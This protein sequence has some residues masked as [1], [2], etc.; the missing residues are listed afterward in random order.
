MSSINQQFQDNCLIRDSTRRAKTPRAHKIRLIDDNSELSQRYNVYDFLPTSASQTN[1][2]K[3]AVLKRGLDKETRELVVLKIIAKEWFKKSSD[4]SR[5]RNVYTG[6]MNIPANRNVVKVHEVIESP[7]HYF[8][9][10]EG[11]QGGELF[12]FLSEAEVVP[13]DDCKKIIGQIV[14]AVGHLHKYGF[15]HRDLK[16]ENLLFRYANSVS[17]IV[18]VDLDSCWCITPPGNSF[19]KPS[20]D[21]AL[22]GYLPCD[23][24]IVGTHG[25]LAPEVYIT[26]LYSTAADFWSIGVIFYILMTGLPPLPI[27]S[28]SDC[29]ACVEAFSR[30]KKKGLNFTRDPWGEFPLA[31]SLCQRML[32]FDPQKRCHTAEEALASEWLCPTDKHQQLWK[33]TQNHNRRQWIETSRHISPKPQP[34]IAKTDQDEN[35][36]KQINAPM[37]AI[38]QRF[39][40]LQLRNLQN[41]SSVEGRMGAGSN[42]KHWRWSNQL[43]N[44]RNRGEMRHEKYENTQDDTSRDKVRNDTSREK[45]RNDTSREKVRNDTSREK[46]RNDTS[47]EKV[48][49]DTSRE[50]VRNDTSREKVRNDRDLYEGRSDT[51]YTYKKSNECADML[52]DMNAANGRSLQGTYHA[53]STYPAQGSS[54]HRMRDE[55]LTELLSVRGDRFHHMS[56]SPGA[57][58]TASS[59]SPLDV[60]SPISQNRSPLYT[61]D[62]IY[63]LK[64]TKDSYSNKAILSHDQ[65]RTK[66]LSSAGSSFDPTPSARHLGDQHWHLPPRGQTRRNCFESHKLVPPPSGSSRLFSR[67]DDMCHRA[68][69]PAGTPVELSRAGSPFLY[70]ESYRYASPTS[71]ILSPLLT[72]EFRQHANNFKYS[73][74]LPPLRQNASR[75]SFVFHNKGSQH[76]SSPY[77]GSYDSPSPPGGARTARHYFG[78]FS[79]KQGDSPVTPFPSHAFDVV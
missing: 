46:V 30:A 7:T 73:G 53:Q 37:N 40:K 24:R 65:S 4:E 12:D 50:K 71:P 66:L 62:N 42:E 17:E 29:N 47:R 10:M 19:Y 18:L 49:N 15:I 68:S 58:T 39:S 78:D 31:R 72:T 44:D 54:T 5:W 35:D 34:V 67:N 64:N 74:S 1:G 57:S 45:V 25:Y 26:R 23:R 70:K 77:G 38:Q 48:R 14:S 13:E 28:M 52:R 60:Y 56:A 27:Q 32:M 43:S 75:T 6:I 69:T 51:R 3:R 76:E 9:I 16:P 21:A 79:F 20:C 55:Y 63:L 11:C 59:S 36:K 2:R 61:K 22:A 8:V 33:K 41:R